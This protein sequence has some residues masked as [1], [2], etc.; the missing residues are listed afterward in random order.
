MMLQDKLA[1]TQSVKLDPVLVQGVMTGMLQPNAA[2]FATPVDS[3][4]VTMPR[5]I[6]ILKVRSV[7]A[8]GN[9][10]CSYIQGFT[11]HAGITPTGHADP[12]M[13][14]RINS[15]IETVIQQ[16][17][18]PMGWVRQEK[19]YKVYNIFSSG[20]LEVFCQRPTDVLDT[21]TVN[22]TAAF[23]ANSGMDV[24]GTSLG[25]VLNQ[26]NRA[27]VGSDVNNNIGADYL[28]K[29]INAGIH[30]HKEKALFLN[31]YEIG[32][33]NSVLQQEP[34]L[35]DNRFVKFLSRCSGGMSI[36]DDFLFQTL[37]MVDPT[38]ADRF[39]VLNP[40]RDMRDPITAVTPDVGDHWLGQDMVTLKAYTLIESS[41]ALATAFGMQKL[42]F[43]VTNMNNPLG[44]AELVIYNWNTKMALDNNDIY[45]LLER[46][47]TNTSRSI[48]PRPALARSDEGGCHV[49]LLHHQDQPELRRLSENWYTIP[50]RPIAIQSMLTADKMTF[51]AAATVQRCYRN[52]RRR[53]EFYRQW[54]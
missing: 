5:F 9:E 50:A 48:S 20:G 35:N 27:V 3:A 4:W 43:T 12:R 25:N 14:H 26:W 38:V 11:D 22:S 2:G 18:T 21:I 40:V 54:Y 49:D 51:D 36:S 30:D 37:T 46:S 8:T 23:M 32:V 33:T 42:N 1:E 15:I 31:S 29:V 41:V 13:S 24:T 10:I 19:L 6:F 17:Q 53:Y 45:T 39:I 44:Y 34:S 47:K 52:H 16:F 7:D 28:C